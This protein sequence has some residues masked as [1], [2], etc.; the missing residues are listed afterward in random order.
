MLLLNENVINSNLVF[1]KFKML[2]LTPS[3]STKKN[4]SKNIQ[5]RNKKRIKMVNQEKHQSQKNVIMK[6]VK[7]KK[8]IRYLENK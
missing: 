7:N 6:E 4:T 5:K 3:I 1:H 2:H 8:D